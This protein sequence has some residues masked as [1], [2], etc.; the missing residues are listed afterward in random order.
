MLIHSYILTHS[1]VNPGGNPY[2]AL[3]SGSDGPRFVDRVL[4]PPPPLLLPIF[5]GPGLGT[6]IRRVYNNNNFFFL[7]V[8]LENALTHDRGAMRIPNPCVW[9]SVAP[10]FSPTM[11]STSLKGEYP[12]NS[13]FHTLDMFLCAGC[14]FGLLQRGVCS[15]A[16]FLIECIPN[17]VSFIQRFACLSLLRLV[18]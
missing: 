5:K 3:P 13:H 2:A 10:A 4:L 11:R 18:C 8:D 6:G 17:F 9:G 12:L 16:I 14:L 1:P 7:S 15:Y